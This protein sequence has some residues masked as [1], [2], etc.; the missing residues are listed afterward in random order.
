MNKIKILTDSSCDIPSDLE[1]KYNITSLSFSINLEEQTFLEKI[2]I[3]NEEF[4]EILSKSETIPTTSQ[5][6]SSRFLTSFNSIYNQGFE[7]IIYISINSLGSNTYN[8]ALSARELFFEEHPNS[9]NKFKIHII[10][11]KNYS[12]S[13]GYP[14]I[15]S[16]KKAL[17]SITSEEIIRYL[18]DWFSCVEVY[19]IPLS[20]KYVK[21]SGRISAAKAF[22]GEIM[23]LRP[24]ISIIDGHTS[25]IEKVRGEK[26]II[27]SILNY[28]KNR[29]IPET[30]YALIYGNI[31]EKKE[32]F[33]KEAQ[34]TLG[35][36]AG[37]HGFAGACITCNTGPNLVGIAIKGKKR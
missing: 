16:A 5:I 8:S 6:T 2:D 10:D 26:N 17:N 9:I 30:P 31:K 18:E 33:I 11:S 37:I 32:I 1:R 20:L 28:A 12:L 36:K 15:E 23:G 24:L 7:E 19:F 27:T 25:V 22:I 29:M 35:Q 13:Y 4:L 3:T 14:V 34:K 21:K